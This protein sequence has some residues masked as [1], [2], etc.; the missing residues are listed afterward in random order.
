MEF[1]ELRYFLAVAEE[2]HFGR[3]ARRLHISQPPLTHHIQ[4]LEADLGVRLFDRSPRSVSLTAAGAAMVEEARKIVG[5]IDELRGAVQRARHG[6]IGLLRAGFMSSIPF[7]RGPSLFDWLTHDLTDV[8]VTWHG[9]RTS[10]QINALRAMQIDIGFI[11]LPADH[12][13]LTVRPIAVGRFVLAVHRSHPLAGRR[14]A[15]L[16]SFRDD[17]FVLPP[18]D[19]SPGLYD[20]LIGACTSAGFS[21]V[22]R[23]R[24]REFLAILSLVSIG[25]GVALVP[26]WL[27]EAGF[28]GVSFIELTDDVPMAQLAIVWHPENPSPTLARALEALER[29]PLIDLRH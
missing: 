12:R 27:R 4:K 13:G 29:L 15:S 11:H 5:D 10:E 25:S 20:L 9:L 14:R 7:A 28:P 6:K 18:R 16:K 21:P 3:A 26:G 2:L 1:R 23:H 17:G 19:I 22:V 8:T 24:A